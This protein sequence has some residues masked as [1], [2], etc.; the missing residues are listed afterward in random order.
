MRDAIDKDK[1]DKPAGTPI[2]STIVKPEQELAN[3]QSM[4]VERTGI[5]VQS[6]SQQFFLSPLP[7]PEFLAKY[8]EIIPNGA[9]RIF[10]LTEQQQK[11]RHYLEKSVIDSD[12]RRS[13]LGLKLGFSL[14]LLLSVGGIYLISQGHSTNGL[15]L[16]L[17][18]LAALASI[19][20]YAKKTKTR[21]LQNK[22]N[23][24]DKE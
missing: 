14:T 20:V 8:N 10:K 5:I 3:K 11:H 7:P 23:P 15:A 4:P 21:E 18:P 12:I 22:N 2:D 6:S 17:A 13:D 1:S 16:I 9:E 24:A 19:F